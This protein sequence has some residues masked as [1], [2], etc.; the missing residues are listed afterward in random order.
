MS[1]HGNGVNLYNIAQDVSQILESSG[2]K[3]A[4]I[5]IDAQ[6]DSHIC[7]RKWKAFFGADYL[8]SVTICITIWKEEVNITVSH[9]YS[10]TDISKY[11]VSYNM[12]D[13]N[14]TSKIKNVG[15]VILETTDILETAYMSVKLVQ[16]K[17]SKLHKEKL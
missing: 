8:Q 12:N 11:M 13:P 10:H 1:N 6:L 7:R 16:Q 9:Y 5:N 2:L 15:K 3:L 4:P 14:L 17:I